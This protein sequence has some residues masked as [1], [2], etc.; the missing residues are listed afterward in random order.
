[1]TSIK[2]LFAGSILFVLAA[3]AVLISAGLILGLVYS[4]L[5][6]VKFTNVGELFRYAVTVTSPAILGFTVVEL[7]APILALAVSR[8][9]EQDNNI[10][11]SGQNY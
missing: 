2:R 10:R 8:G 4:T 7:S 5:S 6:V 9:Q 3:I 1:M 11:E